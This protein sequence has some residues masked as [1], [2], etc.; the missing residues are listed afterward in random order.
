M[1]IGVPLCP[2][3]HSGHQ[4]AMLRAPRERAQAGGG[5]AVYKQPPAPALLPS[6][7]LYTTARREVVNK[8]DA[9]SKLCTI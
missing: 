9:Y 2:E 6:G 5:E 7:H 3:G 8:H 4:I 1:T